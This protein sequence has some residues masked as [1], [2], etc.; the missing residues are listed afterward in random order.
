MQVPNFI[1]TQVTQ[2]VD[3]LA[4]SLL[5]QGQQQQ[6]QQQQQQEQQQQQQQEQEQQQPQLKQQQQ[7]QQE[8][9]EGPS[10]PTSDQFHAPTG[11]AKQHGVPE[12]YGALPDPAPVVA[13]KTP[14][15]ALLAASPLQGRTRT[16][17][18]E[19][20]H[21]HTRG[22]GAEHDNAT[23]PLQGGIHAGVQ[24]EGSAQGDVCLFAL[25][26]QGPVGTVQ[27]E[28]GRRGGSAVG[29]GDVS[30][31]LPAA[32]EQ[33]AAAVAAATAAGVQGSGGGGSAQ[34]HSDGGPVGDDTKTRERS[35]PA[36]SHTSGPQQGLPLLL[37]PQLV[38]WLP[39]TE[40]EGLQ[41]CCGDACV[42]QSGGTA[43]QHS[44]QVHDM[45]AAL[46]R[47]AAVILHA[48][49]RESV[50]HVTCLEG[51]LCAAMQCVM[52]DVLAAGA[53]S[54]SQQAPPSPP[55]S[56]LKA[57]LSAAGVITTATT[58][59]LPPHILLPPP[60]LEHDL[61]S[62]PPLPQLP[63]NLLPCNLP[64]PS[65][66]PPLPSLH[67]QQQLPP[68]PPCDHA[69]NAA[70]NT[71]ASTANDAA[72]RVL[73]WMCMALFEL[74]AAHCRQCLVWEL[75]SDGE[76]TKCS[77]SSRS[78]GGC[79]PKPQGDGKHCESCEGSGGN[80]SGRSGY[81]DSSSFQGGSDV[82]TFMPLLTLLIQFARA[83][84]EYILL[85]HLRVAV[86]Q[87]TFSNIGLVF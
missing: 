2:Q 64:S 60:P 79:P 14:T 23:G 84:S 17:G 80:C 3:T 39:G 54:P 33:L 24:Y 31:S 18:A 19:Y 65:P 55:P 76:G 47:S 87:A 42:H 67:Q 83:R 68:P 66:S 30:G 57:P 52:T 32:A 77:S 37:F 62:G 63:P 70:T 81:D 15:P 4:R 36:A 35:L 48:L 21:S 78:S 86:Q 43:A 6:Q 8:Q 46:G 38:A 72:Q 11:S 10:T 22:S 59:D 69:H 49:V 1:R 82:T 73:F 71:G 9:K 44:D 5:K 40:V 41:V 45:Q 75:H 12:G 16:T 28:K 56:A 58:H 74:H 29:T 50:L 61:S 53:T 85:H 25:G 26:L 34:Q 20:N 51:C 13:A 7:Q 27:G